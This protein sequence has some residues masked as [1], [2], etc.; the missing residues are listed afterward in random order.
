MQRTRGARTFVGTGVLLLLGPGVA[1]CGASGSTA[2]G[3]PVATTPTVSASTSAMGSPIASTADPTAAWPTFSSAP[4]KL[5]FRYDPTWKP[6]ECPPL[7]YSPLIVLGANICGQIEPSFG[8]DSVASSP[9]PAAAD[10][11]CD[12]SQPRAVSTTTTVDGVTGTKQYI[13]YTGAAY[14]NCRLPVMHAVVYSFYTGGRAYTVTYLY[15]PSQGPD[16]ATK[17]DQ[18]VQTLR[19]SA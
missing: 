6:V 11:R 13:D 9:A 8:V 7:H 18:M 19:F 3:S 17:V 4:G 12:A 5:S 14:N 2:S 10:L 15:I 16:Q 1:A